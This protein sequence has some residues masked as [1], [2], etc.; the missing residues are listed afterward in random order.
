MN[1]PEEIMKLMRK[2]A[3]EEPNDYVNP[4][5]LADIIVALEDKVVRNWVDYMIGV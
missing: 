2:K 5:F 4:F 1:L 3:E